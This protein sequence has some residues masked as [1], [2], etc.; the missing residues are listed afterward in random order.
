[1]SFRRDIILTFDVQKRW[2]ITPRAFL[3]HSMSLESSIM[4]LPVSQGLVYFIYEYDVF[5]SERLL[6]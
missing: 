3:F 6:T 4:D 2:N 1:M 5:M